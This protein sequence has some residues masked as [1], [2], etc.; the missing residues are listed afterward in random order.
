MSKEKLQR[1]FSNNDFE[2]IA[3]LFE[4]NEKRLDKI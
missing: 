2:A 1:L 4:K 3:L